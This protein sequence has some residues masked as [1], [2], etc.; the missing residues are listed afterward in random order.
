MPKQIEPFEA[1]LRMLNGHCIEQALYVIATTGIADHI[2]DGAMSAVD[3]AKATNVDLQALNRLLTM[4]TAVGVFSRNEKGHFA[5]TELGQTLRSDVPNSV[6]DRALFFGSPEMW[7]VW[8]NLLYS[9]RTGKSSLEKIHDQPFYQFLSCHPTVGEPFDRYMAKMSEQQLPAILKAYNFGQFRTLIDIGGGHGRTLAAILDAH[10]TMEG[11]LFDLS[12]VIEAA[13]ALD[14]PSIAERSR[15]VSGDMAQSLASGFDGYLFKWV[16]MD[17]P[18]EEVI[19]VLQ[20]CGR[21]MPDSAKVVVIEILLQNANTSN[22]TTVVD[23]NALTIFGGG[24]LRTE[25]EFCDLFA[26]AGLRVTECFATDSPNSIIE[27]M[28]RQ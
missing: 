26:K 11:T 18:D 14:A 21:V 19:N 17:R 1:M 13:S 20:N 7:A 8:G 22:F 12:N 28:R 5:L 15:R 25:E 16:L 27:G 9:V 10:Q 6:R 23:L 2:R 3:L 4:L 24:R